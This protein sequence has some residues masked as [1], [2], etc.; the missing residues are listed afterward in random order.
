MALL[1]SKP[2]DPRELDFGRIRSPHSVCRL[3]VGS[4]GRLRAM[5]PLALS[6]EDSAAILA[7]LPDLL[8]RVQAVSAQSANRSTGPVTIAL[9]QGCGYVAALDR[10][11]EDWVVT[12]NAAGRA[13]ANRRG[14]P[15]PKMGPDPLL[16]DSFSSL[17]IAAALMTADG[18][19]LSASSSFRALV[20]AGDFISLAGD[21]LRIAAGCRDRDGLL[22]VL[23]ATG[24][25]ARLARLVDQETGTE[26]L[27]Q[28]TSTR[29]QGLELRTL[30]CR[31]RERL[32][33]RLVRVNGLT[34]V[35]AA[36]TCEL[37]QGLDLASAS[38]H[39]KISRHTGRKYLQSIFQKLGVNRQVDLVRLLT[40]GAPDA[41]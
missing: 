10:S 3:L 33:D 40:T 15:S 6:D 31:R 2:F 4:G 8:S 1:Q 36:L 17:P 21:R 24:A 38:A 11:G 39:L 26:L 19:V 29:S 12:L 13:A 28:V 22:D 7:L 32:A 14:S 23:R 5:K 16:R 9:P 35:E 20:E 27:C 41:P 34:R 18:Q 25:E 37:L 30:I